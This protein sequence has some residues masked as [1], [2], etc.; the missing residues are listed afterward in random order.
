MDN[1]KPWQRNWL[2]TGATLV[3]LGATIAPASAQSVIIIDGVVQQ[4]GVSSYIY[5]SPI[6]TPIPI[7][8]VTEQIP[9]KT[10]NSYRR[11]S[12]YNHRRTTVYSYPV[13]QQTIIN[14]NLTYPNLV[15]PIFR[16]QPL[17]N[18]VFE[19]RSGYHQ[20]Y[21]QFRGRSRS[22]FLYPR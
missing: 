15:N 17:R 18:P 12:Q 6:A 21:R 10:D 2:G 22:I 4:P 9:C 8:R 16:N 1:I 3:L 13:Y 20:E 5:S 19:Q 7:N 14:P 11:R